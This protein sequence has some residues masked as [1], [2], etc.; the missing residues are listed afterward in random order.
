MRRVFAEWVSK[1]IDRLVHFRDQLRYGIIRMISSTVAETIEDQFHR[2][3]K[4]P[5]HPAVYDD[6]YDDYYYDQGSYPP[7]TRQVAERTSQAQGGHNQGP[8]GTW[9]GVLSHAASILM[10]WVRGPWAE[11]ILAS[12]VTL[13]SLL[14][15]VR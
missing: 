13:I 1:L 7:Q 2:S 9:L 4:N 11:P 3:D 10:R 12:V 6:G 8:N 14:L 5:S 15:V